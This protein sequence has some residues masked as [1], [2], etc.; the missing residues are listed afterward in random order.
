MMGGFVLRL[1]H[2]PR[3]SKEPLVRRYLTE[4]IGT[5]FLVLTVC[6][7][8]QTGSALA[9]LGIGAVLAAMIFAGGHISGAHYNPAVTTA[10]LLR[11]RMPLSDVPGYLAAQF[12]GG[13]LAAGISRFVFEHGPTAFHVTGRALVAAFLVELIFTFALAFVVLNVATSKS[14]PNNSFYGLAIGFTVLAGVVAVGAISG[15]VFN[16]AVALGG[17][18]AGLLSWSMLPVYLVANL[19]GGALAGL[20]FN[21][22]NPGD[23]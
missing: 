1:L 23:S 12:A 5:F 14:H 22:L 9:P 16:P 13:L 15:G 18:V 8:V 21:A 11:G 6:F 3:E 10:V 2:R 19:G 7:A 4:F 17:S 20:A